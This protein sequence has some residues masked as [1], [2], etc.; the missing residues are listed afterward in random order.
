MTDKVQELSNTQIKDI[1]RRACSSQK[2]RLEQALAGV[3]LSG[4][5]QRITLSFI[6]PYLSKFHSKNCLPFLT[7]ILKDCFGQQLT[8]INSQS[9]PQNA[10]VSPI[11]TS[12]SADPFANFL[13]NSRTIATVNACINAC[14]IQNPG[15]MLLVIC[16]PLSSGK[17]HL[18]SAMHKAMLQ[19][20]SMAAQKYSALNFELQT[21]PG[22]FWQDNQALLLDD[23]QEILKN[24]ILQTTLAGYLDAVLDNNTTIWRRA[25]IAFTGSSHDLSDFCPRLANRLQSGLVLELAPADLPMKIT[26]LEKMAQQRNLKLTREQ[27][28]SMARHS[29]GLGPLNGLLQKLEFY[30]KVSGRNLSVEE[31]EKLTLPAN[32]TA[33]WQLIIQ[34]VAQK[35]NLKPV[36]I[37]GASRKH[38]KA[39]ARKVAMY[40]CRVKLG[41]S[42]PE[43]GKLFGGRDHTTVLYAIRK[44]QELRQV[45]KFLHKLMTELEI[46]C[47]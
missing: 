22:K 34:K 35:F 40:F 8:I 16:G 2:D 21:S 11:A 43:L 18:L 46:E 26:Y 14:S 6:H 30:A 20:K 39:L 7:E 13:T 5:S 24:P 17:S 41:L 10:P 36:D 25:V 23:L 27:I 28:M 3:K 38:D 9:S 19:N 37:T 15:S 4:N 32:H 29:S 1:L 45:D 33:D 42:Y 47:E 31:L 12:T 44:I